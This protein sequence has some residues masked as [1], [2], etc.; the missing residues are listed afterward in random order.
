M[1]WLLGRNS[2]LSIYNKL[3]LYKQI[4]KPVQT[5][6]AVGLCQQEQSRYIQRFQDKL[7]RSIGNAPWYCRNSDLHR[8]LKVKIVSQT[9]GKSA[10]SHEQRLLYHVNVEAT[11]TMQTRLEDSRGS[12]PSSQCDWCKFKSR[13]LCL[14]TQLMIVKTSYRTK[15][16]TTSQSVDIGFVAVIIQARK[17]LLIDQT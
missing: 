1:Y 12:N 13:V 4:L 10:R 9:I 15:I 16:G 14:S 3:L 5:Y 7:L 6:P 17:S 8:D 2:T 11:S